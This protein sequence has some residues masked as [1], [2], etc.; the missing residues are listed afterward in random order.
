MSILIGK[1]DRG[2]QPG[3]KGKIYIDKLENVCGGK[4]F[5]NN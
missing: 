4:S 1:G 3:F 2:M 5:H